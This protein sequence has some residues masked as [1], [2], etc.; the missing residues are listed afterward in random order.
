[1]TVKRELYIHIGTVKTGTTALQ[2]FLDSNRDILKQKG[3]VYPL[4]KDGR[5]AHYRLSW[6]LRKKTGLTRWDWPEDI[7]EPDQEWRF[8]IKQITDYKGIISSE[9]FFGCNTKIISEIHKITSEFNVKIFV[10]WRRPDKLLDS[11][12]S[13][14]IKGSEKVA[15]PSYRQKFKSKEHLDIWAKVFGKENILVRP[16]E[17]TQLYKEDVVADFLHHVLGLELTEEFTLPEKEMNTRLHRIA[18]EYKRM[19]NLIPIAPR[20]KRK[21]VN[22]L[23]NIS[24]VLM[25][26][27]KKTCPVFSPRQR[28]ELIERYSKENA[29]IAR[30]YLGR[31]D[32]KLF[33]EPLP[34]LN[35]EW[36]PYD[37]LLEED[38]KIINEYLAK[39]HPNVFTII[40]RGIL[41]ADC[42]GKKKVREA[43][44]RLMPGIASEFIKKAL[45]TNLD[46]PDSYICLKKNMLNEIYSSRTWKTGM[47]LNR[48]YNKIPDKLKPPMMKV[49]HKLYGML[50]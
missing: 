44:L 38:A 4:D 36:H 19:V 34:D 11:W 28:L 17:R 49:T 27:G 32:G 25:E 41:L 8:A 5:Y 39:H 30:E 48:I 45:V 22:P 21:I 18:L 6:S 31:K 1:M 35:E 50:K 43:A 20:E 37:E 15:L 40:V 3:F 2:H 26:L 9:H 16:Y 12:Y 7:G 47:I 14:R 29:V 42:S 13:Q 10:Y 46:T 23:R 24:T 33:Y